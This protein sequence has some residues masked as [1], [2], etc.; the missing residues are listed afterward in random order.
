MKKEEDYR[1]ISPST[2]KV[3]FNYMSGSPSQEKRN[4]YVVEERRTV[5]TV[6]GTGYQ[7]RPGQVT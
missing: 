5:N 4:E 3:R 2:G 6:E 1:Q 7:I